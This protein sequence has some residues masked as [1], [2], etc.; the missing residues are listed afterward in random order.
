MISELLRNSSAL[1]PR[2][3]TITKQHCIQAKDQ[4]P[5]LLDD[6]NTAL[7]CDLPVLDGH[8]L[9]STRVQQHHDVLADAA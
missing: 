5:L 4:L 7:Q 6:D 3:T 1:T 2:S 9:L 8:H